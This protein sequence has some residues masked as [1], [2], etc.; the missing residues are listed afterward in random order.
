MYETTNPT[1]DISEKG[2]EGILSSYTG[3]DPK[4]NVLMT[5]VL[6]KMYLS[7]DNSG[8]PMLKVLY[9]VT[10]GEYDGYV[11]WDNISLTDAAA[12]KWQSL[13]ENILDISWIDLKTRLFLVPGD[14][15][16]A[17]QRVESI[18][19]AVL[20]GLTPVNFSV[21]YYMHEGSK[22]TKVRMAFNPTIDRDE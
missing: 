15:S 16:N 12:F 22:Q 9:K 19:D 1:F 7:R 17:G 14:E 2:I 18:G 20:D 6:D 5:G 21:S 13:C 4:A 8:N 11:A 10:E 3:A